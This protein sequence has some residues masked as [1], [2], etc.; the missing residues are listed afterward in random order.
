M[1]RDPLAAGDLI[2]ERRFAY[3]KAAA[4]EGDLSAAAELFEQTL[5]RAPNWAAAWFA[6]GEAREKA[7]RPRRRGSSLSR[8]R[9]P[10]IP[11]T[12][13]ARRRGSRSLGEATLRSAAAGLCRAAV[14]RLC[15]ALRQA[16]HQK[17]RLSRPCPHRRGLERGR[18]GPP[19]RLGPRPRLRHGPHGRG[20]PRPHRPFD[21]R[22]PLAGHDREGARARRL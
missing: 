19:L 5:E 9:S 7:R 6:L 2:A 21:R 12:R 11:P 10:P 16:S 13:K 14:R 4:K 18:A 8:E 1:T 3:A 22:R 20:A 15:L 17:S